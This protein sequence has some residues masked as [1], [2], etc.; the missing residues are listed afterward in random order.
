MT[1]ETNETPKSR[2]TGPVTPEGKETVS[3]NSVKHGLTGSGKHGILPEE[4]EEF[5][6]FKEEYL[7][8]IKPVGPEEHRLAVSVAENAFR[9]RRAHRM[10][11]SLFAKAIREAEPGADPALIQAQVW[12]DPPKG[13]QK[14][15]LYAA[16]IQRTI[17]RDSKRLA[18]LQTAR[19]A[20]YA[21]AR[22]EAI[23]LC[24][25]NYATGHKF[26]PAD[27][28]PPDG[29]FGGFVFSD[30]EMAQLI[31]RANRFEEA[32]ARFGQKPERRESA[33]SEA[34]ALRALD[35]LIG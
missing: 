15:A 16:R 27:H 30:S 6:Q 11:T 26:K 9:V 8:H 23:L 32:R 21:K 5:E 33:K 35:A 13:L 24:K 29:D 20:A 1:P 34:A 19:K 25:L 12:I 18:E 31:A 7:D 17:D 14:I 3:K 10:E 22:E 28:F 2:A 4:R